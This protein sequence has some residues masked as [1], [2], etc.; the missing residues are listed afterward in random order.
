MIHKIFTIYDE[1][2]HAYLPPFN[3]HTSDMAIRVFADCVNSPEHQFGKHPHDYTLFE[4]GN[5]DDQKGEIHKTRS[6][7][8]G[9]GVEFKNLPQP[10]L[11]EDDPNGLQQ[12]KPDSQVGNG[13][14]I[15]PSTES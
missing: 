10:D 2:A 12:K 11:F 4:I 3:L 6:Q 5:F 15:Q 9:N 14:P 1:K 13:S 8:L 7:S